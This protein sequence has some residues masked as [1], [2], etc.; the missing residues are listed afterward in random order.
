M[1]VVTRILETCLY[2]EDLD[3]AIQF[4]GRLFGFAVMNRD[5]RFCAMNVAPG[6][7]LLLF[8]RGGTLSA[9]ETGY[10]SIPPHDGHGPLHMALAIPAESLAEWEATL[11]EAGLAVEGTVRWPRGSVSLYFRDP[12]GHLIELATPGLWENY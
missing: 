2:V 8:R 6:S 12:D 1:P 3:R 9:I 10:G 7:V 5:E 11:A 4:Y